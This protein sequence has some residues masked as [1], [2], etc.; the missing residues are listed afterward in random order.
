MIMMNLKTYLEVQERS[1]AFLSLIYS[2][3][4]AMD[5]PHWPQPTQG[6]RE[7]VKSINLIIAVGH[8]HLGAI[9]YVGGIQKFQI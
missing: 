2:P 3:Y 4:D 8:T 1:N 6:G 5:E 9:R 7:Y